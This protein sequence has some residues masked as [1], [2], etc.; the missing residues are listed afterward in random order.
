[1]S[2]ADR[3]PVVRNQVP[4]TALVADGWYRTAA[5]GASAVV[6][7][8][9]PPREDLRGWRPWPRWTARRRA[10]GNRAAPLLRVRRWPDRLR[11]AD[12]S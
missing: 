1:M 8:G 2:R 3:S 11:L 12:A 10:E 5:L 9:R 7:R 4:G 6:H